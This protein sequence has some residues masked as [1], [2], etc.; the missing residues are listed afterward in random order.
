M[1]QGTKSMFLGKDRTWESPSTDRPRGRAIGASRTKPADRDMR[2]SAGSL[3]RR[4]PT[5]MDPARVQRMLKN[6]PHWASGL[7][8]N[9]PACQKKFSRVRETVT[10]TKARNQKWRTRDGVPQPLRALDSAKSTIPVPMKKANPGAHRWETK[11]VKKA[12]RDP[13]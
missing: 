5:A 4:E 10:S 1:P 7:V 12:S 9:S 13:P 3:S 2:S 6:T 11:R 8:L